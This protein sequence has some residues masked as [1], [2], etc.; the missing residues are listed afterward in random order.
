MRREAKIAGISIQ[1]VASFFRS[2]LKPVYLLI[3]EMK[4]RREA[5]IAGISIQKMENFDLLGKIR[6]FV[7]I[8]RAICGHNGL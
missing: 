7:Q 3:F 5:K 8:F 4:M 1:K 6:V 2:K